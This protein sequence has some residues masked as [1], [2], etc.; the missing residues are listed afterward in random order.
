MLRKTLVILFFSTLILQ[1]KA[2]DFNGGISGGINASWLN[3]IADKGYQLWSLQGGLFTQL[4]TGKNSSW[5]F[6]LRYT[7]KGNHVK[8]QENGD[9]TIILHYADIPISYIYHIP[10]PKDLK[11]KLNIKPYIVVGLAYGYLI[12]ASEGFDNNNVSG[13]PFHPFNNSDFSAHAGLGSCLGNHFSIELKY[14]V[15]IIPIRE[16]FNDNIFILGA[17]RNNVV[18]GNIYYTF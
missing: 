16:D 5:R 11:T 9:Y 13:E 7:K 3:N 18:S 6:E 10:P 17:Q 15:S 1:L 4:N 8:P 12:K 14:S 2:Q